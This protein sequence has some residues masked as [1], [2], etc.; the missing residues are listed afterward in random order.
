MEEL[1]RRLGQSHILLA[2]NSEKE[3]VLRK[4]ATDG[5]VG[6]VLFQEKDDQQRMQAESLE[7]QKGIWQ[8]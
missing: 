4:D 8:R 6:A 1:K 2:S 5:S 3:F 7:M